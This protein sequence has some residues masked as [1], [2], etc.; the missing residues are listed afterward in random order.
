M[1]YQPDLYY[2]CILQYKTNKISPL[3]GY[4]DMLLRQSSHL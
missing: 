1:G 4:L 2:D 3:S